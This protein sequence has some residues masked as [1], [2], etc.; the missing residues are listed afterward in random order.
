MKINRWLVPEEGGIP[1]LTMPNVPHDLHGLAPRTIMGR[2]LW[3]I[4][5][6]ACYEDH[7]DTC[8]ICGQKLSG[9]LKSGLPL[10]NAHEVYEIDYEKKQAIF[11]RFCCICPVCHNFIHSGR[12]ITM[13]KNHH[14]MYSKEYLLSTVEH[15]F[16]LIHK[17]NKLH[18]DEESLRCFQTIEEW[19]EE[20]SLTADLQ[21]LIDQYHIEFYHVPHTDKRSDWGNWVLVYDGEEYHSEYTCQTDWEKAMQ[22]ANHEGG[23][24]PLFQGDVFDELR[25]NI[26]SKL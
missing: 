13:Y 4:T 10:H 20:P 2:Q 11:K 14:P 5:R 3:D 12:L 6:R 9:T 17:W 22:R 19:L 16:E 18:E 8:E 24:D 15:G 23:H 7:E 1:L 21:A 26:R 25:K